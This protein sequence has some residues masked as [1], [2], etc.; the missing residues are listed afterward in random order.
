MTITCSSENRAYSDVV[1]LS[2]NY[3]TDDEIVFMFNNGFRGGIFSPIKQE[4]YNRLSDG[5]LGQVMRSN[6]VQGEHV[7][8][9]WICQNK[10]GLHY[11]SRY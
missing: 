10:E 8:S 6:E 3:N 11:D 1:V 9:L 4:L 7:I 5:Y 2:D